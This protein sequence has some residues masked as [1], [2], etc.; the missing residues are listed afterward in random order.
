VIDFVADYGES[1]DRIGR[2]GAIDGQ[3]EGV[4]STLLWIRLRGR[5]NVMNV[6]VDDLDIAARPENINPDRRV[7]SAG[8]LVVADLKPVDDDVALVRNR[9]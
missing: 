8:G 7:S 9:E 6:V 1:I 5:Y 4:G 2:L 3:A